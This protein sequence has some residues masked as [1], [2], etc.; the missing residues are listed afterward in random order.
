V[1]LKVDTGP[2]R[3]VASE[4]SITKR[5]ELAEKGLLILLG[6]PNATSVHQ[7]MDVMYQGFKAATY[8]RG[9]ALLT[10]KM[11]ARGRQIEEN[12]AARRNN[13]PVHGSVGFLSALSIGFEDLSTVV[14]GEVGDPIDMKPFDK[15]FTKERIVSS[16][17]RVGFVPF[18]RNCLN[19]KKVRHEL[20]EEGEAKSSEL[21]DLQEDYDHLVSLARRRG[22]NA[23][24]F[25]ASI[26][27]ALRME[28]VEDEDEQVKQLLETKSAFSAGGIWNICGTRISNA[29]VVIRAQK[30]QLA[31]EAEKSA[32]Q[33]QG[34]AHRR[35]KLLISARTALQ[36]YQRD[37]NNGMTDKDW[38]DIIRW[39]LPESKAEG[40]MKDLKKADAI[41]TKLATLERDWT[42]YIPQVEAI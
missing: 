4:E 5:A 9:E 35:S 10:Q 42:T 31:L 14:N 38:V 30:Q 33:A 20:G 23:G 21:E 29:S 6:L 11:M 22:F 27:V 28:R 25:D 1:I 36:K 24:V 8:S 12:R 13:N 3:M 7:E 19:H 16:W 34:R 37:G 2:G 26:P 41:I 15:F 40:L 18:S 17:E 32:L 39:V